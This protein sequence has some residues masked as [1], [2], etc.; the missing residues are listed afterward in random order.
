MCDF[1]HINLK[2]IARIGA[3]RE[4]WPRQRVDAA[5]VNGEKLGGTHCGVHLAAAGVDTLDV[6]CVS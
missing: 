2:H 3:F 4:N 5:S 6:H 1:E